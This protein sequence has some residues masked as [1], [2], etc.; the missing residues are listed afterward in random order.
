M[1]AVGFII[2]MFFTCAVIALVDHLRSKAPIAPKH[3]EP[4]FLPPVGEVIPF[5]N[6]RLNAQGS[7][8]SFQA[9]VRPN[10]GG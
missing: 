3:A 9:P 6:S 2:G 4:H 1:L 5:R 10:S 8:L 7:K